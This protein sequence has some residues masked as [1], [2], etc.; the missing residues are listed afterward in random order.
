MWIFNLF[1]CSIYMCKI[2][3]ELATTLLLF[4]NNMKNSNLNL[5]FLLITF[6]GVKMY[7]S[8][9]NST[10]KFDEINQYCYYSA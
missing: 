8:E 10:N 1:Y 4:S 7:F 5:F 9:I 6:S 2:V 3:T